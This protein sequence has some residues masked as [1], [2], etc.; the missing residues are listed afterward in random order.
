MK[1]LFILCYLLGMMSSIFAVYVINR[2]ITINAATLAAMRSSAS[3][4]STFFDPYIDNLSE[5]NSILIQDDANLSMTRAV[6]DT[7]SKMN[8]AVNLPLRL[9]EAMF[10]ESNNLNYINNILSDLSYVP[11]DTVSALYYFRNTSEPAD[12]RALHL[13]YYTI[14]AAMLYDCL[15]Y[16]PTSIVPDSAKLKL[17]DILLASIHLTVETIDSYNDLS[18]IQNKRW[19]ENLPVSYAYPA[20]SIIQYRLQMFGAM[21]LAA[22]LLR[23]SEPSLVNEMNGHLDYINNVLL[24]EPIP[25]TFPADKQYQGMLAFHTTNSGAYFESLGYQG[26]LLQMLCP[27]FTAYRRL[28][29]GNVNYYNNQY[30]VSWIN[31]LTRKVTPTEADWPYNDDW[32]RKSV[33]P[34]PVFFYYNN[35]N[36]QEVRN[37]CAWYV[38]SKPTSSYASYGDACRSYILAKY[39]SDPSVSPG[40]SSLDYIPEFIRQGSSSNSEYSILRKPISGDFT[41]T[42]S[43]FKNAASMC[44]L[45]ENSFSPYHGQSDHLSYS[46]YYKGMP[47]LIDPGY[48]VVNTNSQLPPAAIAND[49]NNWNYGRE[50]MR[51]IYAHNMIVIDPDEVKEKWE[52]NKYYWDYGS[53]NVPGVGITGTYRPFSAFGNYSD[54]V[55]NVEDIVRDPCYRDYYQRSENLDLIRTRIMYD[56]A[57]AN[58]PISELR[59]SFMRHEDVF[60]IYD[61]IHSLDSNLHNYSNLYQFGSF[62]QTSAPIVENPYGFNINKGGILVDMICGSTGVYN[63]QMDN[64]STGFDNWYFP[65]SWV[66]TSTPDSPSSNYQYGHA[67]GRT[68]IVDSGDISFMMIV[69]PQDDTN[70]IAIQNIT[71]EPMTKYGVEIS[72]N[73]RLEP[74]Q[75]VSSFFG[76]TNGSQQNLTFGDKVIGTNGKMFALSIL[77]N[78][79]PFVV[80]KSIVLLEGDNLILNG[81]ELYRRYSGYDRGL[82][83]TYSGT[84]LDIVYHST[85]LSYPRFKVVRAGTNP[86]H[87]TAIMRT[88][89][90]PVIP[91][92]IPHPDDPDYRYFS[93]DIIHSLAYDD[94]YFYVNYSWNELN[95]AGLNNGSLTIVKGTI[96]QALLSNDLILHGEIAITGTLSIGIGISLA[97]NP[98]SM[99]SFSDAAAILNHGEL[100]I[101]GGGYTSSRSSISP[102]QRWG[103]ITTSRTGILTCQNAFIENAVTGIHVRG[104]ANISNSEIK[105]CDKGLAI[106]TPRTFV[107]LNNLLHQNHNGIV[108]SNNYAVSN[109]VIADNEITANQIGIIVYNSNTKLSHNNIYHNS[110]GGIY[111]INGSEPVLKHNLITFSEGNGTIWP[112]IML[113]SNSYPVMDGMCNDINVDGLGYSLHNASLNL[114]QFY[115]RNNYWGS[116]SSRQI[117]NWIHPPNWDVIF[118]PFSLEPNQSFVNW[119]DDPFRQALI[120]EESG[121]LYLSGQLYKTVVQNEPDS[122]YALQSLGRLN[123]LYAFSDS[124]IS[125]LRNLYG[126]YLSVCS[127]SMLIK[128]AELKYI[129]LDRFD[130][131]YPCAVQSYDNLLSASVSEID[132]LLCLLDIAYTLQEMYYDDMSKGSPPSMS[133]VANGLA[134]SS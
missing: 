40:I 14:N 111:L 18:S 73:T 44:I 7:I 62:N 20:F 122:L 108:I 45:H 3:P 88:Q 120:A 33:N 117:R 90:E 47:F 21:G 52:L 9:N 22:L 17:R 112:E 104:T 121:D 65:T 58:T 79:Q 28:S 103:G 92:P 116:T 71:H 134:I 19:E 76:C 34:S 46:F 4:A 118:E 38:K 25:Y 125:D 57:N 124:L 12:A 5:S 114:K 42:L 69:I 41:T 133:Y 99:I 74:I 27:F 131:M 101:D 60:L 97:I 72:Q 32:G 102:Y 30:I 85:S 89:L 23:E 11:S 98:G 63:N 91:E 109:S 35:S 67:R 100:I 107:I 29:N 56:N 1:R 80:D 129:M 64:P 70:P 15:Y 93:T 6:P 127:D 128:S 16:V 119:Y 37:K 115:A 77:S 87:F 132:S 49:L 126:S 86:D 48:R 24:N 39:L 110:Q 43:E 13:T 10:E 113:E 51:S 68:E 96:P 78:V 2:T 50:W 59:R 36:N 55:V 105:G 95:A 123:S 8:D 106:E 66:F 26:Q 31:D 94:Q 53:Y 54:T 84:S 83:A 82:S 130:G 81:E 75:P 61:D